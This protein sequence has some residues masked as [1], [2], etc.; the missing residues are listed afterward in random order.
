MALKWNKTDLPTLAEKK[1]AAASQTCQEIIYAGIDVQL[2]TGTQHFSLTAHDQTNIDSMFTAVTLGATEYPYHADGD[3][4]AMF[5]AAD[6]VTLYV[7]YKTFVTT[8]TTYNNFLRIWIN[9]ETDRETLAAIQYGSDLPADLATQ[10]QTI[11]A[12]AQAQID[13]I[14]VKLQQ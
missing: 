4:C 5:S 8:Q 1:T 2:S 12:Q 14:I 9:R 13:A 3:Q 7:A 11:L 10:M 6:I